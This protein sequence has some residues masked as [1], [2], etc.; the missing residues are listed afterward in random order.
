[1]GIIWVKKCSTTGIA[2]QRYHNSEYIHAWLTSLDAT[3]LPAAT[4]PGPQFLGNAPGRPNSRPARPSA[5]QQNALFEPQPMRVCLVRCRCMIREVRSASDSCAHQ[6][7]VTAVCCPHCSSPIAG[8]EFRVAIA[9]KYTHKVKNPG[10]YRFAV[11]CFESAPGCIATG[12]TSHHASWFP[13]HTWQRAFCR[14]C[15]THVG[16]LFRAKSGTFYALIIA[17]EG[18]ETHPV[19]G[20]RRHR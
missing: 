7:D 3:G 20:G 11:A 1:M 17:E 12:E 10:G 8:R 5:S 18:G 9:G 19:P 4:R 14:S 13:G 15:S 2:L 6:G 16:W